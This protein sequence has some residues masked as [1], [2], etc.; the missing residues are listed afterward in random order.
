MLLQRSQLAAQRPERPYLA[1]L[2]LL[3]L[4]SGLVVFALIVIYP[5]QD[6]IKRLSESPESELSRDYL[7]NLLRT[8]PDNPQ[9]RLLLARQELAQGKF[10]NAR[11][12]LQPSLNGADSALRKEALWLLWQAAEKEYERLPA[13]EKTVEQHHQ[14]AQQLHALMSETWPEER[15]IEIASMAFAIGEQ[16][17]AI[18]LHQQLAQSSPNSVATADRLIKVAADTLAAG[19]Y[20]E[21]AELLLLARRKTTD[22]AQAKRCFLNALRTLQSGNLLNEAMATAEREIEPLGNDSETL[23]FLTRLARSAGRPDLADRY[24]RQLLRLSLLRQLEQIRLAAAHDGALP[25]KA[26]WSAVDRSNGPQL[27]FDDQVYTLGYEVFLENRKLDDAWKVAASAVR[28]APDDMVW[29]ERLAKVAEWTQRPAMALDNWLLLAR[30]TQRDDAWQA[31]LRL[32]PGLFNDNALIAALQYELAHKPGDLKLLRELVAAWER[33]GEPQPAIDFLS[34]QSRHSHPPQ[35]QAQILEMLADLA[36]RAGDTPLAQES[37]RQLF[38]KPG[39][40]TPERAVRATVLAITHGHN[41]QGLAWLEQAQQ[42]AAGSKSD[43]NPDFWRLLGQLAQLEQREGLAIEAYTQLTK[44]AQ[45][46]ES[47]LTTLQQMLLRTYPLEAAKLAVRSWER[48]DQPKHLLE[49]LNIYLG[50]QQWAAIGALLNR[51]DPAPNAAKR[52]LLALRRLPDFLRLAGLYYQHNGQLKLARRD[53]SAALSLAP[54]SSDIQQSLLWLLI[55]NNDGAA[56]RRLLASQESRW[57]NN[58]DLHDALASAYLALSLPKVALERY[59]TPHLAAHQNDFLWLMNY[60]DALE[61]NQQ[62]DRA[63][64]LRRYLLSEEWQTASTVPQGDFLRG[65]VDSK[66][67]LISLRRNWLTA[68]NLDDTRRLARS[69][70]LITQRGGDTGLDALRELLR[71]D[72]DANQHYSNAAVESII[73]WLQEAGEY[74]AERGYLWQQYSRSLSQQSKRPLWAEISVALAHQ[75]KAVLGQLLDEAGERLPRYDR[76]NAARNIGALRLAQ[77]DAFDTQDAQS[78]DDP[79]HMQ[80]AESLLEFSDH[81]GGTIAR[82]DLGAISEQLAAAEWHL[83]INPKLSLDFALGHTQRQNK[84]ASVIRHVPN[85]QFASLRMNWREAGSQ[86]TL[87]SEKRSSLTDYAPLQIEREQRIDDRLS[88][89]ISL[90][91]HLPSLESTALRVAGM[92]DRLALGLNYQATRVDRISLEQLSER[93]QLQ[94]GS[95]IGSGQHTSLS[96]SHALRQESRDLEVDAF[97]STH[98]FKRESSYSDPALAPLL[99]ASIASVSD[100][101]PGFFLP[102]NFKFYGLRLSTDMRYEKEYSRAIR[103]YASLSRTWHSE[104]GPGYDLRLGLAGSL[105]GADHFSLTWGLSKA[106]IQTGGLSREINFIYRIHY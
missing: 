42:Q 77:S 105:L 90:G 65:A 43:L 5:Q 12:T 23:L 95:A 25:Q 31:V 33:Q 37:W 94:T 80:L 18:A 63:W 39:T 30:Q 55:D 26:A 79:L 24:V 69:R 38:A 53:L 86:T 85:E 97:W 16:P 6:L 13:K 66:K 62:G 78:D 101:T 81:A 76:I 9:L 70:L 17:L 8:N 100:L 14:L 34:K 61:Q 104:L 98:R 20:R 64:R 3:L 99:P 72:R 1:P 60:A 67:D 28:Q 75:D 83:A 59:L 74:T 54:D 46:E 32:A 89:Q 15:L 96:F 103:P 7:I 49:A 50:Q 27:P 21:S 102:D 44:D 29:R 22:P 48:F 11:A 106:G 40:V 56:L 82:R 52:S 68:S 45:A 51:L 2:W 73:G 41:Q 92:K 84:D 36:E 19:N 87:L 71:L 47:D 10:A 88:L 35:I 57:R 91:Q 58:A 93:Y 4:L